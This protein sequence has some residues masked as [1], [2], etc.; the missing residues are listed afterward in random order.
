MYTLISVHKLFDVG[1]D[2]ENV[3]ATCNC[4]MRHYSL[5]AQLATCQNW[6]M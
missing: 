6:K 5:V 2:L 3:H 4:S 1:I